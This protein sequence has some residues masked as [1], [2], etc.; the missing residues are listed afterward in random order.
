[1][2]GSA[3]EKIF[4]A[5]SGRARVASRAKPPLSGLTALLMVGA[6]SF[7]LTVKGTAEELSLEQL[8]GARIDDSW[9]RYA[10]RKAG[11][12]IDIPT[13]GFRYDV[14][15][16]GAD[17]TLTSNDGAV[18]ITVS[19]H[20][21]RNVLGT[22]TNDARQSIARLFDTAVDNAKRKNGA[23]TYKVKKDNFFVL[24]GVVDDNTYYERLNV[25]PS[26]PDGFAALRVFHRKSLTSRLNHLVTRMSLSLR[27]TCQAEEGPA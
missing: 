6:A 16:G 24:S 19:A 11:V 13:K 2:T 18:T 10:N 1:M 15:A 17:L 7:P 4:A 22:A 21:V 25:S 27:A 14:P 23:I 5:F 12:A 20:G 9:F 8:P 26:C 3:R